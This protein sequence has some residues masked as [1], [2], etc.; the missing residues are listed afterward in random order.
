[1]AQSEKVESALAFGEKMLG[2]AIDTVG[3]VNV[4]IS[5]LGARDPKIVS[6]ALLCR[7]ISNCR[8]ALIMVREGLVIE[9]RTLA[10]CCYENLIWSAALNERGSEFVTD[11]LNDDAASRKTL[12]QVKL[13][14][15]SRAGADSDAE[16][17]K[18]LRDLIRQSES[19]FPDSKKLRVDKTALRGAVELAYA[20]FG[21]LSLDAAHPTI[22]AIGRH[23]HSEVDG[24]TRHLVID[25]MP[26]VQERELLRTIWWSCDAL[27]GAT[28]ALNEIVGGTRMND[29]VREAV[30]ELR[31]RS[32][33]D[34]EGD[35]PATPV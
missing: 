22:T 14:L 24:D 9:A 30:D 5:P 17:A 25:V 18:I 6:L 10:R 33:Q 26:D 4:T 32:R 12:G 35:A 20:T 7:T 29:G 19:K 8:G 1:V 31:V 21:Q 11:M 28:V 2:L 23:L 15:S 34:L 27:L 16:D 3:A 13:K